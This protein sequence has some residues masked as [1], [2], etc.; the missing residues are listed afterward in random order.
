MGGMA[1][2][3]HS[4]LCS[5]LM[6]VH[7]FRSHMYLWQYLD[8]DSWNYHYLTPS[9]ILHLSL[10]PS[11]PPSPLPSH[12]SLPP[13]G[14]AAS[15][16]GRMSVCRADAP[17]QGSSSGNDTATGATTAAPAVAVADPTVPLSRQNLY[18]WYLA[19]SCV[20]GNV[21]LQ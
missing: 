6:S 4:L 7:M 8:G 2:I 1:L 11:L 10:L 3:V 13:V 16:L 14:P 12:P 9:P 5:N 15:N 20:H 21:T 19:V 17:G 18:A